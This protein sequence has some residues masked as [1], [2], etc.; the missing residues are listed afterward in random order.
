MIK[1]SVYYDIYWCKF[2]DVTRIIQIL[3]IVEGRNIARY[4]SQNLR[5]FLS[6][7]DHSQPRSTIPL[8]G[9]FIAESWKIN[10]ARSRAK[11]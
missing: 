8:I 7:E 5:N 6:N 2:N 10:Y 11:R 3:T 9:H 4:V 1:N